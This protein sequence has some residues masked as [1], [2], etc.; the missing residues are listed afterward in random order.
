MRIFLLRI[1]VTI[2]WVLWIITI[3]ASWL[4]PVVGSGY[5]LFVNHEWINLIYI[6]IGTVGLFM[7]KIWTNIQDRIW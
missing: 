3:I 5:I 1:F 4:L 7:V 6:A 2:F